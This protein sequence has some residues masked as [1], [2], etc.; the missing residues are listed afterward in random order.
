MR[1]L[2]GNMSYN[3]ISHGAD[4]RPVCPERA[5]SSS[6]VGIG[7]VFDEWTVPWARHYVV[8]SIG[9]FLASRAP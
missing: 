3:R 7:D 8:T 9:Q 6:G 1:L 4:Q 2:P 5:R